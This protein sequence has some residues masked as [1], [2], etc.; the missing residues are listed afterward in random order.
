[1][2]RT[3]APDAAPEAAA[4]ANAPAPAATP[5]PA[6]AAA[7]PAPVPLPLPERL[8]AAVEGW[9]TGHH[10]RAVTTGSA[11]IPVDDKAALI[12]AVLDAAG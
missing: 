8:V 10:H 12:Q 2:S 4:N 11:L 5:A 1:M 6:P 9:Y 3:P 7:L